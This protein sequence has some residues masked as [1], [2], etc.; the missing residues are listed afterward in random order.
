MRVYTTSSLKSYLNIYRIAK[1]NPLQKLF[2]ALMFS[3]GA[4]TVVYE[5]V[6]GKNVLLRFFEQYY[7]ELVY[8]GFIANLETD[9]NYFYT[10]GY[11]MT[12]EIF[13][14]IM[15]ELIDNLPI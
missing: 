15:S 4:D 6:T 1:D 7:P 9:D 12:D 5:R 2:A 13:E 8:A 11:N 3:E 14:K 10:S